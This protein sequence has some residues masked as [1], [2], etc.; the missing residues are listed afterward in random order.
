MN[1]FY[2]N[3]NNDNLNDSNNDNLINISNQVV[4][5]FITNLDKTKISHLFIFFGQ[6]FNKDKNKFCNKIIDY[7]YKN[8]INTF[9]SSLFCYYK[10]W[11]NVK[12]EKYN[13]LSNNYNIIIF[14]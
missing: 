11:N 13:L 7:L 12:Y 4:I 6:N 3:Y 1:K 9:Y 14:L 10:P 8:E 2:Y 5:D